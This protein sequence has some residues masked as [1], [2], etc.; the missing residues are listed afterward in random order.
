MVDEPSMRPA[1]G[2]APPDGV[3]PPADAA[4]TGELAASGSQK[5]QGGKGPGSIL[6]NRVV[7][8]VAAVLALVVVLGIVVALVMTVFSASPPATT[9]GATQER[10][11]LGGAPGIA[12]PSAP[13]TGTGAGGSK[14]TTVAAAPPPSP[15]IPPSFEVFVENKDP[16]KA[17]V[18]KPA[19]GEATSTSGGA[20]SSATST[21]GSTTTSETIKPGM[22]VLYLENI[23]TSGGHAVA[24]VWWNNSRYEV[25]EGDRVD[26]SP[27]EVVS[28]GSSSATFLYGDDRV[29]LRVGE[30]LG[31]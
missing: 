27:W 10:V 17:L 1:E 16:F 3:I 22:N 8:V 18:I 6:R 11:G 26:T 29:T 14:P 15:E 28:I 23:K 2:T 25:A 13:T 31:K 9:A 24:V 21:G 4:S 12:K 20:S 19:P 30:Q 7:L 5:G